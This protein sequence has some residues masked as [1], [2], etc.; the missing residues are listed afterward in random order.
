MVE[1]GGG[2]PGR[3]S[4]ADRDSDSRPV[5]GAV[6]WDWC[7]LGGFTGHGQWHARL[8]ARRGRGFGDS[9]ALSV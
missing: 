2:V 1:G 4:L 3:L 9:V 5:P 7:L 8:P 6:C